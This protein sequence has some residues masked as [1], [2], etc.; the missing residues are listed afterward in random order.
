[1]PA[2]L[3]VPI[4]P[5]HTV[6]YPGGVLP[7]RIFE[8]RYLE[9]T[10]ACLRDGSPFGVCRIRE[11]REVGLPAIPEQIG[12]TAMIQSWEMP[13]PGMFQLQ[14]RGVQAFR[15]LEHSIREN[16]LMRAQIEMLEDVHDAADNAVSPLCRQVL[17][18]AIQQLG[19][20]FFPPPRDFTNVRWVSYRLAEVLPLPG[21]IKQALLEEREDA[22]RLAR[23]HELLTTAQSV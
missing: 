18:Q 4:F 3:E 2:R 20:E 14:S 9:M 8:Q 7:L 1:M 5:L 6:L 11:G 17:G 23:L 16:D 22:A 21:D 12:C 15:I 13:H 10:K 19:P